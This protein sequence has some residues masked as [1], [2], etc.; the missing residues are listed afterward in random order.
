[1]IASIVA[2]EQAM[3]KV[4]TAARTDHSSIANLALPHRHPQ[5]IVNGARENLSSSPSDMSP[6]SCSPS[7]SDTIQSARPSRNIRPPPSQGGG[8][9]GGGA[10]GGNSLNRQSSG[11]ESPIDVTGVSGLI[12]QPLK[13]EPHFD[14]SG[15][16]G[17]GQINGHLQNT[18]LNSSTSSDHLLASST[19]LITKGLIIKNSPED[20]ALSEIFR[21][22]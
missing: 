22:H 6:T 14:M 12:N 5:V 17:M 3:L 9:G 1:M 13:Q 7:S 2:K 4:N 20:L 16:L 10:G 19:S 11:N 15:I 21:F 18:G 8:G